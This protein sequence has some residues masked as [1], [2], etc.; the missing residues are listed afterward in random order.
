MT[1]DSNDKWDDDNSSKED[2]DSIGRQPEHTDQT[3]DIISPQ[4][5]N[6]DYLRRITAEIPDNTPSGRIK[7]I[8]ETEDADQNSKYCP[9]GDN[10]A[11]TSASG[12]QQ[13]EMNDNDKDKNKAV[14][15]ET[16]ETATDLDRPATLDRSESGWSILIEEAVEAVEE[17]AASSY[18]L[19]PVNNGEAPGKEASILDAETAATIIHPNHSNGKRNSN[20]WKNVLYSTLVL[21]IVV[22]IGLPVYQLS[23]NTELLPPVNISPEKP[24]RPSDLDKTAEQEVKGRISPE[25]EQRLRLINDSLD[26]IDLSSNRSPR[27]RDKI[28]G[29]GQQDPK[30][31]SDETNNDKSNFIDSPTAIARLNAGSADKPVSESQKKKIDSS[32]AEEAPPLDSEVQKP[33]LKDLGSAPQTDSSESLSKKKTEL[34]LPGPPVPGWFVQIAAKESIAEAG[35]LCRSLA[36]ENHPAT[37][38]SVEVKDKTY[39]RILVGPQ[40]SSQNATKLLSKLRKLPFVEKGAFV[41]EIEH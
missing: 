25:M 10:D 11:G 4:T 9:Q 15:S 28:K 1:N 6:L 39:F 17:E 30:D 16:E 33:K 2:F 12:E 35:K 18:R 21:I 27:T 13:Q 3:P 34:Q 20:R 38:Q 26:S 5:D 24:D 23:L 41:R 40:D 29:S 14:S 8:D 22:C 32:N 31:E 19:Q 37:I 7:V 36:S